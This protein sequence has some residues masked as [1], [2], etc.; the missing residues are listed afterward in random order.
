MKT[1]RI[2]SLALVLIMLIG[3]VCQTGITVLADGVSWDLTDG[4]LTISGTGSMDPLCYSGTSPWYGQRLKVKSIVIEEGIT[5]IGYYAFMSCANATS[6]SIPST[7]TSIKEGAF[8]Y[9]G[10]ITELKLPAGLKSIGDF[11]FG[12]CSD[13]TELTLPDGLESIGKGAFSFMGITELVIPESVTFIDGYALRYCTEL[14][15]VTLPSHM[16]E[17]PDQL[18]AY[19]D[20]LTTVELPKGLTS[21]GY[22]CFYRSKGLTHITIPAGIT[23]VDEYTFYGCSNLEEITFE[24]TITSVGKGAFESTDALTSFPFTDAITEIG[25]RAFAESG[26]SGELV[27]PAGLTAV[28][29]SA[30]SECVGITSITFPESVEKI[31]FQAFNGCTGIESL[32]IPETIKTIDGEAFQNCCGIKSLTLHDSIESIGDN[33]FYC[34]CGIED[35]L[36]IPAGIGYIGYQAF[37]DCD[38]LTTVTLE[39]VD[40][41][42]GGAPFAYCDYLKEIFLPEGI[43][44]LPTELFSNLTSLKTIVLPDTLTSLGDSAFFGNEALTSV[45]I[46]ENISVIPSQCFYGCVNLEKVTA[47]GDIVRIEDSAFGDTRSLTEFDF[48]PGLTYIGDHAF[49]RSGLNGDVVI[50]EGVTYVG[51][52]AFWASAIE[53]ITLPSTMEYVSSVTF[54]ETNLKYINVHEDNQYYASVDG[55]LYTEDMKELIMYNNLSS[56]VEFHIPETVEKVHEYCFYG[57]YYDGVALEKIVFPRSII[58][59]PGYLFYNFSQDCVW[60]YKDS[61]AEEYFRDSWEIDIVYVVD[62]IELLTPPS[63]LVYPIGGS[64]STAGMTVSFEDSTGYS[65]IIDSGFDI[66]EYD[67]STAGQHSVPVGYNGKWINILVTVDPDLILLPASEHPYPEDFY[68]EWE[69]TDKYNFESLDVTFAPETETEDYYDTITIYDKDGNEVGVYS[70]TELSGATVNVPGNYFKIVL[71]SDSSYSLWGFE[72]VAVTGNCEHITGDWVVTKEPTTEETGEETL[73]CTKCGQPQ[74]TREIP[75][76]E[77]AIVPEITGVFNYTVSMVNLEDIKEIRFAIGHYTTGSEVKG[78]EKNVTLDAAT[79]AKYTDVMGTFIYDLPWMGEY[80]FWVRTNAGESYFLY[81]NVNYINPYVDTYGVMMT[82]KDYGEN[83]K[84]LWIAKGNFNTYNEIK[85]STEFKYQASKNKLDLYAKTTHDFSYTLYEPG[86][87]TV[88]IRYNDGTSDLLYTELTVDTPVFDENGLQVTVS[89]IP[90]IKI[91][92]TAYGHYES[93]ADIKKAAGVR[94][95][96]NKNDIKYAEEYTIQYR[97]EGEVTLIVEYNNGY[98]H[99]HYYNVEQKVAT[100]VQEGNT[101]TFGNL[102]GLYN[103]RYAKGEWKTSSEIKKAPGSQALKASAID[104]NGNIKVTLPTAGTYTFCVQYDDESYN[105]YTVVVE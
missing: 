2:L 98:K 9:C 36:I 78:A 83:Y 65:G 66:G 46:P 90:D 7:V 64:F 21:L 59:L 77:P 16:T 41:E 85:A 95:F 69:Y 14:E 32:T 54:W 87:Y 60:V 57:G 15:S 40:T 67:F 102:D 62:K 81:T 23:A 79:V 71:Q 104:E 11:A 101:V 26:L 3:T 24:G 88:L 49:T 70:G 61:Y 56:R 1:K 20:S 73:Y 55:V 80:T 63:R 58:E 92:R 13:V 12:S 18:L 93:V 43:T 39:G 5:S 25:Y 91:I 105:Y 22:Q 45:T 35:E 68:G 27:L 44:E 48:E 10:D 96:S 53:S 97:D 76:L 103:I 37:G 82:V 89:N 17:F 84:D 8:D 99:F 34:C 100:M 50:P 94:N 38:M 42:Y 31:D 52:Y 51:D 47:L 29:E 86:V 33:A 75:K 6:V 28:S 74:E 19:C 4:V 30:F 72:V